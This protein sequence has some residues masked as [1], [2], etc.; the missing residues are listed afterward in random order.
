MAAPG[1]FCLPFI[2]KVQ[3]IWK[4][5][6]NK[7]IKMWKTIQGFVIKST[8]IIIHKFY[9]HPCHYDH[10]QQMEK[11]SWFKSRPA[12]HAP[13]QV[14]HYFSSSFPSKPFKTRWWALA[15]SYSSWSPLLAPSSP[16]TLVKDHKTFINLWLL[17]DQHVV[18]FHKLPA[19]KHIGASMQT[20]LSLLMNTPMWMVAETSKDTSQVEITPEYLRQKDPEAYSQLQEKWVSQQ[21]FKLF[22]KM[23][24]KYSQITHKMTSKYSQLHEK[25]KSKQ[26]SIQWYDDNH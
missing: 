14:I 13:F 17:L 21:K 22:T 16:R 9:P 25:R 12:L 6:G 23:F 26:I 11:K 24:T 20:T 10:L 4:Y 19:T 5:A 8:Y 15:A 3:Q 7:F 18:I 1:M 2:M